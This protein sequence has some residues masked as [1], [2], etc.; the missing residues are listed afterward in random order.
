MSRK[1]DEP[2]ERSRIQKS[3]SKW[4]TMDTPAHL[5]GRGLGVKALIERVA[6]ENGVT[7][8]RV[9]AALKE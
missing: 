1:A 8:R 9:R 3:M 2:S 6:M 5:L 7:I 4:R